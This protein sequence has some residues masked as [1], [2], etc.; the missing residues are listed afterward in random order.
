MPAQR[1]GQPFGKSGRVNLGGITA[2]FDHLDEVYDPSV[3]RE[4]DV[5]ELEKH[6]VHFLKLL[7]DKAVK[8]KLISPVISLL[9]RFVVK[10]PCVPAIGYCLVMAHLID[11][12]QDT[13]FLIDELQL[14]NMPKPDLAA[15]L[16]ILGDDD[17]SIPGK[18]FA[19]AY[20][21]P[22]LFIEFPHSRLDSKL[23]ELQDLGTFVRC[24][25]LMNPNDLLFAAYLIQTARHILSSLRFDSI[26]S[27]TTSSI[28]FF[29]SGISRI[30]T[31]A[32]LRACFLSLQDS[33]DHLIP[34]LFVKCLTVR[35]NRKIFLEWLVNSHV[36]DCFLDL[37]YSTNLFDGVEK[38]CYGAKGD[39][40][41]VFRLPK[42]R[43][44]F[45]SIE[46][47]FKIDPVN[48]WLAALGL[49]MRYEGTDDY[50]IESFS[51]TILRRFIDDFPCSETSDVFLQ[52]ALIRRLFEIL[53]GHDYLVGKVVENGGADDL[54]EV[55]ELCVTAIVGN[56]ENTVAAVEAW[57]LVKRFFTKFGSRLKIAAD[58]EFR[59]VH[60]FMLHVRSVF[61]MISHENQLYFDLCLEIVKSVGITREFAGDAMD[62]SLDHF[63]EFFV[64]GKKRQLTRFLLFW[65]AL[66][67][68]RESWDAAMECP[69]FSFWK[70]SISEMC[71]QNIGFAQSYV[72]LVLS[73]YH[74]TH[75]HLYF[76]DDDLG[77]IDG[78]FQFP[79]L[80]DNDVFDALLI[81]I[82]LILDRKKQ[83][84]RIDSDLDLA[85]VYGRQTRVAMQFCAYAVEKWPYLRR[86]LVMEAELPALE[87]PRLKHGR[88]LQWSDDDPV[89]AVIPSG[90]LRIITRLRAVTSDP[91]NLRKK[92]KSFVDVPSPLQSP[93]R[94]E[95]VVRGKLRRVIGGEAIS[96][97]GKVWKSTTAV[98]QTA[99]KQRL[100]KQKEAEKAECE[101][102]RFIDLD[103]RVTVGSAS[104]SGSQ[105]QHASPVLANRVL[106]S[107]QGLPAMSRRSRM[108]IDA[109]AK[110]EED[111]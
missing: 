91:G 111:N 39:W 31:A 63:R 41:R 109:M 60:V 79:E 86:D 92:K 1:E 36:S 17:S 65:A 43:R 27:L 19:L 18:V 28:G 14:Y 97:E 22:A 25:N 26:L 68:C 80:V 70:E 51:K 57:Q 102:I 9:R 66:F 71:G 11:V 98:V 104:G 37:F 100:K 52:L 34:S 40:T 85:A 78:L 47:L 8:A 5:M 32:L 84:I 95:T 21:I 89:F 74:H 12:M 64:R 99:L 82:I 81:A 106:S 75:D 20:F 29:M 59:V 6:F 53:V 3:L 7:A 35:G 44:F 50:F 83:D 90:R 73:F 30:A 46:G 103:E 45:S 2:F 54:L 107:V 110:A 42:S 4:E 77:I 23:T 101:R 33:D 61:A 105:S 48:A 49:F 108:L 87:A 58:C 67:D 13:D 55:G 56:W 24:S 96:G 16:D 62:L 72:F 69:I 88:I 10:Y 76:T 93:T 15:L 38:S 94:V